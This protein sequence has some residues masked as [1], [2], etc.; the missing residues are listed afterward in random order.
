MDLFIL[1]MRV[2][3]SFKLFVVHDLLRLRDFICVRKLDALLSALFFK[4]K[5]TDIALYCR[6]GRSHI[7]LTSMTPN[8]LGRSGMPPSKSWPTR[9]GWRSLLE[10]P[11]HSMIL[12]SKCVSVHIAIWLVIFYICSFGRHFF[13]PI[14][15]RQSNINGIEQL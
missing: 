9:Q 13:F 2:Y 14:N 5:Q 12:R 7:C 10:S 15:M 4:N 6:S 8:H 3:H 11:T 1:P